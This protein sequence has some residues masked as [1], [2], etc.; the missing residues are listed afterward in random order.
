[1]KMHIWSS[2]A[3][4]EWVLWW[5]MSHSKLNSSVTYCTLPLMR[6]TTHFVSFDVKTDFMNQICVT[7]NQIIL[8]TSFT[9]VNSLSKYFLQSFICHK[10]FK[11]T[12]IHKSILEVSSSLDHCNSESHAFHERF[13]QTPYWAK[14]LFFTASSTPNTESKRD[15]P[16][17]SI[18]LQQQP[19]Q[20]DGGTRCH[21]NQKALV[22]RKCGISS[23]C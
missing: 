1:M 14:T 15:H 23:K 11:W 22:E 3:E 19:C 12:G 5:R 21:Q 20:Q 8:Y 13:S 2:Q 16:K 4:S 17:P 7:H 10:E 6:V 9:D 18:S